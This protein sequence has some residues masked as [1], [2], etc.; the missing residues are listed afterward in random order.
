MEAK[1]TPPPAPP[2]TTLT[3]PVSDKA[4]VKLLA[5]TCAGLSK[6]GYRIVMFPVGP[7]H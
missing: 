2:G 3:V 6:D 7:F 4:D 1:T 5:K